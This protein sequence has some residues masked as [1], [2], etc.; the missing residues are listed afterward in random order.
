MGSTSSAVK[1]IMK[2]LG[3]DPNVIKR[4]VVALMKPINVVPAPTEYMWRSR[5]KIHITIEDEVKGSQYRAGNAKGFH[6]F[7]KS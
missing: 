7:G 5:D 2:Q 3:I 4:T 6:C 1:K